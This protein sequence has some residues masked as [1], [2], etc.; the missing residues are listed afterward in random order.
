M[1]QNINVSLLEPHK[2]NPRNDLGDLTELSES[3]KAQGILQNLTV[4]KGMDDMYTVVIGHRRLAAAKL[5]G[6]S[7]V[8]CTVADMDFKTQLSTMLLE[9]MQRSDLTIYEQA[10]GFQTCIDFGV[11]IDELSSKTGFSK[12]TVKHRLKILELDQKDVEQIGNTSIFDFIKLEEIQ[13]IKWRNKALKFLGT[14]NFDVEIARI[15]GEEKKEGIV[16]CILATL[17][18]FAKRLSNDDNRK[19]WIYD[20]YIYLSS[21]ADPS[22][23]IPEDA[24]CDSDD[25]NY[26]YVIDKYSITIYKKEATSEV[27]DERK[28]KQIEEANIR[29]LREESMAQELSIIH[30]VRMRFIKEKLSS[31]S[32]SEHESLSTVLMYML[33]SKVF[34]GSYYSSLNY[35]IIEELT[36]LKLSLKDTED[37]EEEIILKHLRTLKGKEFHKFILAVVV[38]LYSKINRGSVMSYGGQVEIDSDLVDL[39]DLLGFIEYQLSDVEKSIL[40]GTH[41]LFVKGESEND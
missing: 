34:G 31:M 16:N 29:S 41:E 32:I 14:P 37:D 13:D 23:S 9:N 11:T 8:P 20:K 38:S 24:N 4:V 2:R 26:A 19:G 3:I 25:F 12:A 28:A 15:K 30:E 17:D 33:L 35:E 39:Y 22:I 7:E 1:L 5:A 27:I 21:T 10:K 6:L 40:D 18:A 36:G